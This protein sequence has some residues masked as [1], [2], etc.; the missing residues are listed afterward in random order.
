MNNSLKIYMLALIS[1]LVGTSQFSIVGML[2]QVAASASVSVSTAGQLITVFALGNAVGTPLI[3]IVTAKMNQRNQLLMA[4]GIIVLGIAFM[5][6]LPG[7][8]FLMV[9]R[10]I[11][12]IG[13]G[14]FVVSAYAIAAKLASPGRQGGAMSTVAMGY[15]SSLVF[16]VPIGR[17]VAASYDWKS[18]FWAIGIL[19]LLA[20][21]VVASTI[22]S[23]IGDSAVPLRN[24]FSHLKNPRITITLAVTFFVFINYSVINTYIAPYLTSA[25]PTMTDQISFI[26]L[27]MGIAS[28][29]GSRL[30]GF[31]ADRLGTIRTISMSMV[32][33][34]VALVL[35][36]INPGWIVVTIPLLMIWEI[37]CW[38]FGPT[39]NLNLVSLAPEA[40]GILL[41]L[42]SSFVQLG[43]AAGAGIGG[44]TVGIWSIM[45][46][47]WVSSITVLIAAVL[48]MIT[49]RLSRSFSKKLMIK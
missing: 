30:G 43:F 24:R 3:M 14:V 37:A 49:A 33:Q 48:S 41:S 35:L 20:V 26:L 31:M 10:V 13:T 40:S 38:T 32:V 12:G 15:S 47:T 6:V 4:L 16:G 39:Q 34:I 2:D 7:F 8:G 42:N 45:D 36:A 28:L 17:I 18:I 5:L 25:L 23:L 21:F 22:P 1:F 11:I 27:A 9:S 19:S 46:I 29:V 44:V